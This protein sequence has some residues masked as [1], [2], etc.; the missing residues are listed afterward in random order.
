MDFA[1]ALR[2][3]ASGLED[4]EAP[5]AVIGGLALAVHGAGRFTRD[6][7]IVTEYRVQDHL[8]SHLE[9]L[10]YGTLHRS[11]GYSNHVHSDAEK[12]RIDVVY[13]EGETARILFSEAER[14]EILPG[15]EALVPKPEHL[16]AMKVL[17]AKNDP[18]RRLQELADIAG[19]LRARGIAP[20]VVRPYFER[21]GLLKDWEEIRASL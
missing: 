12:G 16:V 13:V 17:A 9:T 20:D 21:H 6:L 19:L 15:L 4:V 2:I 18:T 14:R 7:D 11:R 8:I 3:V 5:W 1:K 10:G